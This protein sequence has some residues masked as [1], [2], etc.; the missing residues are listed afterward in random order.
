MATNLSMP[1]IAG[2]RI[3]SACALLLSAAVLALG[4][5]SGGQAETKVPA[6]GPAFA[7]VQPI[8]KESC[9]GCHGSQNPKEGLDLSSYAS[10]MKGASDEQVI[11]P[12]DPDN[13]LLFKAIS[14]KPGVKRMPPIGPPLDKAKVELIRRWI[15]NGA[16]A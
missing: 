11:K 14:G 2:N 3:A 4:C 10:V 15:E 6:A 9:T 8:F 7:E 5:N 16:K 1:A 12:D 13:S